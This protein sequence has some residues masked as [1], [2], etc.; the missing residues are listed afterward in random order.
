MRR[1]EG[2]PPYRRL[3]RE[4]DTMSFRALAK[5]FSCGKNGTLHIRASPFA[6]AGS[7]PK[8]PPHKKRHVTC[9]RQPTRPQG[10]TAEKSPATETK[11]IEYDQPQIFAR[12]GPLPYTTNPNTRQQGLP[13]APAHLP[14]EAH[15]LARGGSPPRNRKGNNH[16]RTL[17][18]IVIGR[19]DNRFPFREIPTVT[20]FPRNDKLYGRERRFIWIIILIKTYT[21]TAAVIARSAKRDAAISRKG[22]RTTRTRISSNTCPQGLPAEKTPATEMKIIECDQPQIL[23]RSGSLPRN[24]LREK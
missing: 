21:R 11:I 16:T 12:G 5:K 1:D 24:P 10:L 6:N 22:R 3:R 19:R 9:P 23:A 14:A 7:A 13:A 2:V 15:C 17:I 4:S 18:N 8:N 20:S